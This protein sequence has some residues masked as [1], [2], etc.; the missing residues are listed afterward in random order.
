M[1]GGL[2]LGFAMHL[3][4]NVAPVIRYWVDGLQ[5]DCCVNID[6]DC[7]TSGKKIVNF[8]PVTHAHLHRSVGAHMA[9]IRTF[10]IFPPQCLD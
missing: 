4:L 8:G 7:S 5:R 10:P 6:D 1:P 9:K 2:T 3:V